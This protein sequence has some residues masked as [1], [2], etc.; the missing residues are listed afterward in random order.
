VFTNCRCLAFKCYF[1]AVRLMI[2][3]LNK[4]RLEEKCRYIENYKYFF[5]SF[6]LLVN[7][8]VKSLSLRPK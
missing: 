7:S 8:Q 6:T 1:K 5:K 4:I 2:H 3:T